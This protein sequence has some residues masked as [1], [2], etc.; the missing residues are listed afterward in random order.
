MKTTIKT[1]L[2]AWVLT[3]ESADDKILFARHGRLIELIDLACTLGLHIDNISTLPLNQ[4]Q[5]IDHKG[6]I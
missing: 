3:I 1:I 4:Y 2:N 5:V 6:V